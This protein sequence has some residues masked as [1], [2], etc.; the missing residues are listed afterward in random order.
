MYICICICICRLDH[1]FLLPEAHQRLL[2]LRVAAFADH[3]L[4]SFAGELISCSCNDMHV[5]SHHQTRCAMQ[6]FRDEWAAE[7]DFIHTYIHTYMHTCIHRCMHACMHA[8]INTIQVPRVRRFHTFIHTYI[9]TYIHVQTHI[10][11]WSNQYIYIYIYIY[12]HTHTYIHAYIHTYIHTRTYTHT[13]Q[14]QPVCSSLAVFRVTSHF[15]STGWAIATAYGQ[16]F[17][18]TKPWYLHDA[19]G[20]K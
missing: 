12:T 20:L 2:L 8:Y 4:P 6:L 18:K 1:F 17:D 19:L 14:V 15:L 7:I 3:S 5:L 10:Q 13:M 11:C 9:H 16:V